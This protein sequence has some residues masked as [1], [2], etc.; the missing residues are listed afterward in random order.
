MS[1]TR[2]IGLKVDRQAQKLHIKGLHPH[3]GAQMAKCNERGHCHLQF[4]LRRPMLCN[5]TNLLV[6]A[7]SRALLL[8]SLLTPQPMCDLP[9]SCTMVSGVH[10]H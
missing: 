2:G 3:R 4:E 10:P 8:Q 9:D 5:L 6:S 7:T 1:A